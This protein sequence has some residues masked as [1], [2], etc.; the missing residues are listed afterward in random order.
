MHRALFG[1]WALGVLGCGEVQPE[2]CTA[3]EIFVE[4]S[5]TRCGNAGGCAE[6]GPECRPTC[7][8]EDAFD[9][10][11]GASRRMCD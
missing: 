9:C 4:D 5:C 6:T 1:L 11:D 7:D 3:D 8:D 2:D 10:R